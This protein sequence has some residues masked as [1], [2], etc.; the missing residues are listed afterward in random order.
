MPDLALTGP[1]RFDL[2]RHVSLLH[3]A[4]HRRLQAAETKVQP[5]AFHFGEGEGHAARIA[6]R[7]QP[8]NHRAARIAK[9]E[10]LGDLVERLACGIVTRPA[11]QTISA[12]GAN[13][14]QVG[15]AAANDQRQSRCFGSPRLT[16]AFPSKTE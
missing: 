4:Q 7:R 15:V 6:E 9:S 14:K 3:P 1:G 11:Q 10:Q 2:R 5:V 16:A 12:L 8:I 13:F